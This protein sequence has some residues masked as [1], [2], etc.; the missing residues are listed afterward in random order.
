M[1]QAKFQYRQEMESLDAHL[2]I[3]VWTITDGYASLA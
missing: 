3:N 1:V 2:L